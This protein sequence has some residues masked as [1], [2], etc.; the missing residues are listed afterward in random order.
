MDNN[1]FR[2]GLGY[3]IVLLRVQPDIKFGATVR[4]VNMAKCKQSPQPD[5]AAE[6]TMCV[7]N[8][9]CLKGAG[10]LEAWASAYHNND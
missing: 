9:S 6:F 8:S 1:C 4:P 3:D 10:S 5:N 7:V 2:R